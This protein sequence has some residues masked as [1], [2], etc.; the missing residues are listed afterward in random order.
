MPRKPN[1][2]L[3]IPWKILLPATVAGAVELELLDPVTQKSRYG[4]RSRLITALLLEWLERR[5]RPLPKD[6][7]VP[8]AVDIYEENT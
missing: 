2:D 1:P 8:P 7:T 3:S 5:G 4:E 6:L